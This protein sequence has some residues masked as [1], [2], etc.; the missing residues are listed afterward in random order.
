MCQYGNILLTAAASATSGLIERFFLR[1][2]EQVLSRTSPEE[3]ELSEFMWLEN[4][5][6]PKEISKY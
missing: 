1:S 5:N 2:I 6:R 3:R 4:S